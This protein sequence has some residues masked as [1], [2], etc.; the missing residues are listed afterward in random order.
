MGQGHDGQQLRSGVDE[1]AGAHAAGADDA[2][3][4]RADDGALQGDAGLIDHGAGLFDGGDALLA[5]GAQHAGGALFGDQGGL[6]LLHAGGGGGGRGA[7]GLDAL[8]RD[9]ALFGQPAVTVDLGAGQAGLGVGLADGGG[10]GGDGRLFLLGLGVDMAHGGDGGGQIGLGLGQLGLLVGIVQLDQDLTG[11]DPL[12]VAHQNLGHA[13]RQ[14]RADQGGVGLD[15][16]VVG[17]FPPLAVQPPDR[18]ADDQGH[19]DD[20]RRDQRQTFLEFRRHGEIR[21]EGVRPIEAALK[22][23]SPSRNQ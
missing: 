23:T 21:G 1:L 22:W 15:E 5:G 3:G 17:A 20:H 19:D 16:G 8:L 6:G 10:A 14:L 7:L 18:A 11:L 2:G 12:V 4:G 13:P 9:P